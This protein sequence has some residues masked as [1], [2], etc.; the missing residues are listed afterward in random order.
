MRRM[1]WAGA[2]LIMLAACGGSPDAVG[3][4]SAGSIKTTA[5]GEVVAN[6]ATPTPTPTPTAAA[7]DAVSNAAAAT[8][9]TA[10]AATDVAD[11]SLTSH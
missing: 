5:M 7:V 11:N 6:T 4:N 2:S 10:D 9:D 1:I 3:E 8:G